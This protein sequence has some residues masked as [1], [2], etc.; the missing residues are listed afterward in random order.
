ML[1]EELLLPILLKHPDLTTMEELEAVL[2]EQSAKS[3]TSK[4]WIDLTIKPA[5]IV[6]LYIRADHKGNFALHLYAASLMLVY[7]F[8]GHKYNYV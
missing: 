6:I 2:D 8:V 1:V 7:I 5:F 3:K 4:V